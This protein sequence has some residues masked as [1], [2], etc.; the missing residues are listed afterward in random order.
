M[1]TR[2]GEVGQDESITHV[3][4]MW[5][6]TLTWHVSQTHQT[7]KDTPLETTHAKISFISQ[8][9]PLKATFLHS[10]LFSII[11]F[12]LLYGYVHTVTCE[13]D[14]R[15]CCKP[16]TYRLKMEANGQYTKPSL[17]LYIPIIP[18][19]PNNKLN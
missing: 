18:E 2:L 1:A 4:S 14:E 13:M 6:P 17:I 5:Q 19:I 8:Q 11:K 7:Y 15:G 9:I 3:S 12:E 16:D 10:M